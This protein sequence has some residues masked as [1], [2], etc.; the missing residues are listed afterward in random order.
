MKK[1]KRAD[2]SLPRL[3]NVTGKDQASDV[4]LLLCSFTNI[5]K[6]DNYLFVIMSL[7]KSLRYLWVPFGAHILGLKF[8]DLIFY[9]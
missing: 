2:S 9:F 5:K 6:N 1:K 7:Q 3:L 8:N 4:G